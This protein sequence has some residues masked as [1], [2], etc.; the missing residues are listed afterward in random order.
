MRTTH[1]LCAY[2]LPAQRSIRPGCLAAEI[3][4]A[5]VGNSNTATGNSIFHADQ[6]GVYL[7][8]ND[9]AVTGNSI[10]DA[11]IGIL[12]V[13]GSTGNSVSPNLFYATPIP[14][15]DPVAARKAAVKPERP[16]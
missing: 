13:S 4:L 7:Q 14:T 15:Q 9:N 8:G 16:E 3:A 12:T 11:G 10:T 1:S 5:V 6:A 2:P